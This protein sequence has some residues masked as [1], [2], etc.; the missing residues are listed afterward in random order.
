MFQAFNDTIA[1]GCE[2]LEPTGS[3]DFNIIDELIKFVFRRIAGF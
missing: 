3:K 1:F 2:W